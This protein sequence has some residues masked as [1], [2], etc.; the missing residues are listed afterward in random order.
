MPTRLPIIHGPYYQDILEQPRALKATLEALAPSQALRELAAGLARGAYR[1]IVL[2]GMG[3]SCH[4]LHPLHLRLAGHGLASTLM[5]TSELIHYGGGLLAE[6][7]LVVAVSQSG[8]SA[9]TVRLLEVNQGRAAILGVTNTAGSPLATRSA[10]SL[11]T[12]AGPEHSVSCKTYVCALAALAWLGEVLCGKD[13]GPTLAGLA[14]GPA[15]VAAF[16]ADLEGRVRALAPELK[17]VRSLFLVGRGP[18]LASAGT[19]ALITKEAAHFHAEGMSSAAFRHGPLEMIHADTYVLVFAG[20]PPTRAFNERLLEDVLRHGARGAL[21][22]T[23]PAQEVLRPVME[24]LH[25]QV[26]TL[27]LAALAGMEAGAFRWATKVT[28]TE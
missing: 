2:T 23:E 26:I 6:D 5:E 9:E 3:S 1:R 12:Q 8:S 13:P 4:G 17:D 28:T 18:S 14:T 11:L 10:A 7:T 25:A 21:C 19:G 22:A 16:L 27:A 24:I 20:P 15:L